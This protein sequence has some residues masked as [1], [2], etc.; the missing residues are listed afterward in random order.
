[1]TATARRQSGVVGIQQ[2]R[3]LGFD[4]DRVN[5]L[6]AQRRLRRLHR[7]VYADA[8]VPLPP[9]AHL[10]AAQLALGPEAF[11]SHRS[12]AALDGLRPLNVRALELTVVADHTPRR[13]GLRVHRIRTA[14]D[15]SEVRIRDGLRL[16]SPARILVELAARE[17]DAE[18]DRLIADMARRHQL[19]V[20]LIDAVLS[21]R[22]RTPGRARLEAALARYRPSSAHQDKS[23]F[24]RAFAAWLT[25]H[26]DIPP[27][28]RNIHLG[29]WEIDFFWP[30]HRL[31]VETDGDPY[32]CTPA[33]LERDRVKDV[34][35]QRHDIRI[36]RVTEFR[37]DH[38]RFGIR[39]DLGALLE[40]A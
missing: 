14:P 1:M 30:A 4:K 15:P 26:P 11:F 24:E 9:R 35:L 2:L 36:L 39:T 16:S 37:F 3:T 27:P 7:G 19:D 31:A 6:V 18:L 25:T 10:I 40:H 38:D 12:A 22:T 21:R 20:T 28:Q 29:P 8:L 13:A 23:D 5:T 17:T 32:H 34:W 33:E